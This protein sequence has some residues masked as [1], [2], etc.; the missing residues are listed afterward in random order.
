M[1]KRTMV[2]VVALVLAATAAFSVWAYLGSV[3]NDIKAEI[4]EVPVF[5]AR[6]LI[7]SGIEGALAIEQVEE[8][9]ENAEFVP[10]AAIQ[11]RASLE[12][13]LAGSITAGPISEGQILTTD[14][15]VDASELASARLSDLIEPGR[16]AVSINPSQV[17]SAG[18]FIKPGD[19]VNIVAAASF[20]LSQFVELLGDEDAR[21]L[22]LGI[23]SNS[24][25]GAPDVVQIPEDN[26]TTF[27]ETLPAALD[28]V[29]T[30]LQDVEVLAVGTQVRDAT[31]G[32]GLAPVGGEIITLEVTP[33]QAERIIFAEQYTSVRLVLVPEGYTP[34]ESEGVIV[35]DLFS[36]VDRLL[37][38][39]EGTLGR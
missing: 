10:P 31:A 24:G 25:S 34:F 2:L 7:A 11:D 20:S 38:E 19:R 18:G 26:I 13:A 16:V 17:A 8:S 23:G 15:F 22:I 33:E 14:L 6:T 21:E 27:A 1:G 29:Q 9:T 12:E 36:L 5:R 35:D 32:T 28:F 4:V 3:E 30:V 39:L 37:A